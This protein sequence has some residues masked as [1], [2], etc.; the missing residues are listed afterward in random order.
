MKYLMNIWLCVDWF[1]VDVVMVQFCF[2]ESKYGHF[3]FYFHLLPVPVPMHYSWSPSLLLLSISTLDH[4]LCSC[5]RYLLL[6][7]FFALAWCFALVRM[8]TMTYPRHM[9]LF[10]TSHCSSLFLRRPPTTLRYVS[11]ELRR[12]VVQICVPTTKI[13]LARLFLFHQV[14]TFYHNTLYVYIHLNVSM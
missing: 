14:W 9:R 6:I 2:Y 10:M 13:R 7:I 3:Y 1:D 5:S 12:T 4:L 11:P 8:G